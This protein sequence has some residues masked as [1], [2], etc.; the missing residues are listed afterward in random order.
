MAPDPA[1][2]RA[3]EAID[4][5]HAADPKRSDGESSERVYADRIA[6]WIG[7]L[8]DN[9]SP[10]LVIAARAQHLERWTI[11]RSSYPMDRAG[12][13]RWRTAV[14]QRQGERAREL[15]I[16]AGCVPDLANRVALLVSKRA[17]RDDADGQALED[18]A[19]LVFLANELEPFVAAH[20]YDRS[21]LIAITAKTWAKMSPKARDLA[22]SIPLPPALADVVR[23]ATRA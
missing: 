16:G 22:A 11:P 23:Q 15:L 13:H 6:S 18:A 4:L 3:C 7:R 10:E 9:P 1:H 2:Q 20:D 8:V 12:Y 19:C 17:P 5:A 14:Q 21:K